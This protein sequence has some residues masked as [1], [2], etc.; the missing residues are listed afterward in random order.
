MSRPAV[1][2]PYSHTASVAAW[3]NDLA[4]L[5]GG[6]TPLADLRTRVAA[7]T[8]IVVDTFPDPAMFSKISLQAVASLNTFFPA[9]GD[10]QRQLLAWW[11]K[12]RPRTFHPPQALEGV[13]LSA[14]DQMAVTVWLEHEAARDL[15]ER[16]MIMRLAVIRR[17]HGA[18]YRWL[19]GCNLTAS[20]IAVEH[21]WTETERRSAPPSEVEKDEV[22]RAI[23][24]RMRYA[25]DADG[26]E[27]ARPADTPAPAEA[28]PHGVLTPEHLHAVRMGN[29]GLRPIAEREAQIAAMR[30]LAH[31]AHTIDLPVEDE[32]DAPQEEAPVSREPAYAFPWRDEC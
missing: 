11:E 28:K 15:S 29:P 23:R 22:A 6:N 1:V 25:E 18:G 16:D 12:N 13:G 3:L 19:I 26:R 31:E 4:A 8:A 17:Y 27:V 24:T 7:M 20:S 30:R 10:L 2:H 14:E 32:D 5:C 9:F 21:R